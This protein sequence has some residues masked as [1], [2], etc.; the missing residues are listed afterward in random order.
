M[1]FSFL[2]KAALEYQ[3]Q[4]ILLPN[5]H[6]IISIYLSHQLPIEYFSTHYLF[7][8]SY[9]RLEALTLDQFKMDTFLVILPTLISLP[10]LFS[11]TL[12]SPDK[13][14]SRNT[15]FSLL[16]SLPVLKY[17]KLSLNL[18][19]SYSSSSFIGTNETSSLEHLILNTKCH[20][21]E[22]SELLS[23]TP[24]LRKFSCQFS[25]SYSSLS[26]M[27]IVPDKLHHLAL[28]LEETS[29][30][31]FEWF[32][33][34]FAHQLRVLQISTQHESEFL[35]AD[36]WERLISKRMSLLQTFIFEHQTRETLPDDRHHQLMNKFNSS[37]WS[38][39]QWFFT[40][41]H[42]RTGD[43][44][45]WIRLYSTRPYRWN[46]YQLLE[47]ACQYDEIGVNLACEVDLHRYEKSHVQFLRATR[48]ILSE[49]YFRDT[50]ALISNL[51]H[52][53][54]PTQ[55]TEL[56]IFDEQLRFEQLLS[57]IHHFPNIQFLTIRTNILNLSSPQSR[58]TSL[59]IPMNNLLKVTVLNRCTLEDIQILHRFC[60]YWQS[61]EVEVDKDLLEPVIQ[62][63][64]IRNAKQTFENH[65]HLRPSIDHLLFWKPEYSTCLRCQRNHQLHSSRSPCNHHL[66]SVCFREVNYRTIRR[67]QTMIEEH[68]L[69]KDFSIDYLD[70]KMYLWW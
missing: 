63:L 48:L 24:Q 30:D 68:F 12:T 40:H 45:N 4:R 70:E 61:L 51:T 59:Q 8:S 52:L 42:Y 7:H 14:Q 29:F 47:D 10:R 6:R 34:P 15:V 53:V 57:L 54:L 2:S 66:S 64:L 3:C 13:F 60:P 19:Q 56:M 17:C 62:F 11:L 1:K 58:T 16:L 38:N 65:F 5:I 36:R 39:R 35:N 44:Q 18:S 9:L 26:G 31:E 55:L 20:L 32:I 33:L 28:Q 49:G 27:L 50:S 23:H 22:I 43:L 37:F 25:T 46:Q 67:I 21:D 69:L 41:Q